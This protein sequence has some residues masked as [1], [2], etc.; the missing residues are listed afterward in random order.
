MS[1]VAEIMAANMR[2]TH[3]RQHP[4]AFGAIRNF[5]RWSRL[6]GSPHSAQ[7]HVVGTII[8]GGGH[9]TRQRRRHIMRECFKAGE[10]PIQ[11]LEIFD[12]EVPRKPA[13]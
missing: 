11:M 8:Q 3:R 9:Q 10:D 12:E 1:I 13:N 5:P 7:S 2:R 6:V 4:G